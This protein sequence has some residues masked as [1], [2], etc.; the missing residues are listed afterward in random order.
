MPQKRKYIIGPYSESSIFNAGGKFPED[1]INI[2]QRNGYQA[3][4]FRELYGGIGWRYVRDYLLDLRGLLEIPAGSIVVYIDQV[5]P[6]RS[7]HLVYRLLQKNV[8]LLFHYW[9]T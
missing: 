6:I 7:R 9:K 1:I 2:F 8:A 5:S 4:N 3:I